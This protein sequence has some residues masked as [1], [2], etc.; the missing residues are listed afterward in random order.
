MLTDKTVVYNF[1]RDITVGDTRC[2]I[3]VKELHKVYQAYCASVNC[4]PVNVQTF[5]KYFGVYFHSTHIKGR[6]NYWCRLRDDIWE[7]ADVDKV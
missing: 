5:S 3:P 1:M 2:R 7:E 6:V 4:L